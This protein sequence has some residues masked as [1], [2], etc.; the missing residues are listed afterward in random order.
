MEEES[1]FRNFFLR[2]LYENR[3]ILH[4]LVSCYNWGFP[5]YQAHIRI[6]GL[7]FSKRGGIQTQIERYLRKHKF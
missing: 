4:R 5:S 7:K 2:S 6:R 3:D 1:G